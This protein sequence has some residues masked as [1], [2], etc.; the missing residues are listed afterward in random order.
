MAKRLIVEFEDGTSAFVKAAV[1][2]LT[3]G[4]LRAEHAIYRGLKAPFLPAFLAWEDD[5]HLPFLVL[6]DLSAAAWQVP[7]TA[8]RVARVLETC[9][10]VAASCPRTPLPSLKSVW[11][12]FP[13]WADLKRDPAPF[14]GL[15][16]CSAEWLAAN[17]E[18]LVE[19]EASAVLEGDDLI[20]CDIRSDNLC[21]VGER[22]VFI[23]WNWAC[24]GNGTFDVAA[25]L[26][27]LH[28]EGGPLPDEVLPQQ[29]GLAA[30]VSGYFAALAGMPEAQAS[31]K[32]RALQLAQLR[33]A[34]PWA[35]RSLGLP[36]SPSSPS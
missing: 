15:R 27:S 11:S 22:V 10:Q 5:G 32:I 13:G 6:E 1:D 24:L 16:L 34:L 9:R 36:Y 14:L 28:L 18:R 25:W 21:F 33:V 35:A 4:W 20:H 17:I 31:A 2:N 7:W 12:K 30:R 19:A 26:P 29:P 23:D 8:D 3:A